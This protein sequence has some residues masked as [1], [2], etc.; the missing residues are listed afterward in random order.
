VQDE[1]E[2]V[3]LISKGGNYGW[4][5]LEGPLAFHPAWAPGGNTPLD[6]V[7]AIPPI[8]GYRHSDVNKKIGSASIMGGYVYRGSADPCLYGRYSVNLTTASVCSMCLQLTRTRTTTGFL[9]VA[10]AA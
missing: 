5:S 4:R 7:S 3:D 6:S 2:E 10:A 9:F 1:Y 8:M